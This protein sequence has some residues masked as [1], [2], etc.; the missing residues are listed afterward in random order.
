MWRKIYKFFWRILIFLVMPCRLYYFWSWVYRY[1]FGRKFK[2]I[3]IAKINSIEEL[4]EQLKKID[5]LPDRRMQLWDQIGWPGRVQKGLED[6]TV[7]KK[8]GN[9]CDEHAIYSVEALRKLPEYDNVSIMSILWLKDEG[10]GSGH[11]VCIFHRKEED[12]WGYIGNWYSGMPRTGFLKPD[13]IAADVSQRGG[14]KLV[15]WGRADYK[16]KYIESKIW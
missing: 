12:D 9:D 10:G 3:P 5:W 2:D 4:T 6:N 15:S 14:G 11:N 8:H 7:W 1:T 13:I 16:L